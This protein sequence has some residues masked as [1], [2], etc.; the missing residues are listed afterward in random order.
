MA[1]R[2]YTA[3]EIATTVRQVEVAIAKRQNRATDASKRAG[4]LFYD[5]TPLKRN[6]LRRVQRA[7]IDRHDP[8]CAAL[9]HRREGHKYLTAL[10]RNTSTR[11]GHG[12]AP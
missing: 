3:E 11:S 5:Q 12:S 4:D 9:V 7:I 8:R 6:E 1:K 10:A 2:R